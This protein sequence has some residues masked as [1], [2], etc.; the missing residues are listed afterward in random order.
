MCQL[1][2]VFAKLRYS[3]GGER[4]EKKEMQQRVRQRFGELK[5]MD[6]RDGKIPW[7]II[8][9]AQSI[10]DVQNEINKI[11]ENTLEKVQSDKK[12]VGLLWK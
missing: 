12:P 8:N 5:D 1:L 10:E 6:E 2:I 9:A 4:Y 11:V 7:Y 3:Y